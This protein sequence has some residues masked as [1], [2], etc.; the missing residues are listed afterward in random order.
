[1]PEFTI[2]ERILLHL[3]NFRMVSLEDYYNIPWDVTQ[4][5]ISTSLRISRAH[6]SLELKKQKERGNIR[7][8]LVRIYGGKVRRL[9]YVLTQEGTRAAIEL[10]EKAKK[11]GIDVR[12]L[13]DMKKQDTA[14]MLD[15]MK[16]DDR[17]A[18]GTAC[19]FRVAVPLEALPPHDRSVIP[20]DVTG[21]TSI[22][23][24]LRDKMM[25]A[26]DPDEIRE[27]HSRAADYYDRFGQ[28]STI[29][30]EDCRKVERIYHH[31]RA[32]RYTDA[33]KLIRYNFYSLLLSDD[34]GL[35]E[36]VRDTPIDSIKKDRRTEFLTLRAELAL[37]QNDLRTARESSETL[38][39]SDDGQEFG[40]ACLF[41]YLMVRGMAD[42]ARNRLSEVNAS[43]NAL[44][45]VKMAD[46]Y[47]DLNDLDRAEKQ[48]RLA[49]DFI[50]KN[51][52]AASSQM[53][54][55][56]AR[57]DAARGNTA[58]ADRHISKAYNSTNEI[59]RNNIRALAKALGLTIATG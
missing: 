47:V 43:R 37:S 44:G 20:T 9:A 41:K 12:T 22:S 35:Y 51:N 55:T 46:A 14:V 57:L 34:K 23:P 25:R 40:Y 29:A 16:K 36:A 49:K 3:Y 2:G 5:G 10:K 31:L 59:G 27:W 56:M 24:E 53:F 18:L 33:C 28:F 21:F 48:L 45:M 8:A 26:A 17:L 38:I 39:D 1:M 13:T 50:S 30:D 4:D 11:A 15:G 19:A 6:A 58:D 52:E 7:D 54:M 32:G 42:E